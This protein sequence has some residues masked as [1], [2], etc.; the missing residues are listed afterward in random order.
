MRKQYDLW[1]ELHFEDHPVRVGAINGE[2]VFALVDLLSIFPKASKPNVSFAA[3][4]IPSKFVYLASAIYAGN[5][6]VTAVTKHGAMIALCR[7]DK[8]DMEKVVEV[9]KWLDTVDIE[10]L[11]KGA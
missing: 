9:I 6:R 3:K 8:V 7:Q 5:G 11:K 2:V 4:K 1:A 10:K